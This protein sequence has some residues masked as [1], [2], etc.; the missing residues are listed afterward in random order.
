MKKTVL[1]YSRP[2]W[3]SWWWQVA[4][5]AFPEYTRVGVSEF[6]NDDDINF[7]EIFYQYYRGKNSLLDVSSIPVDAED[8]RLR[9]RL[10]QNLPKSQGSRMI[11]SAWQTISQILDRSNPHYVLSITV[12]SYVVD[13]LARACFMR[14]IKF[15]GISNCP[16]TGYALVTE[17]GEHNRVRDPSPDE[18][19]VAIASILSDDFKPKYILGNKPY[20]A[21]AHFQRALRY[22]AKEFIYWL[23]MRRD[24]LNY[25][26]MS[27]RYAADRKDLLGFSVAR[28]FTKDA[29]SRWQNSSLPKLYLP[30]HFVPEATVNYWTRNLDF[31]DYE[32]ALTEVVGILNGRYAIAAKEHPAAMGTRTNDFYE[33]LSKYNN[34]FFIHPD[35]SSLELISQSDIVLTWT[36]TVGLEAA[37][38]GKT[39][40][41]LGDPYYYSPDY[42]IKVNDLEDIRGMDLHF[43]R[44]QSSSNHG[45]RF[46]LHYIM[47]STVRGTF[48]QRGYLSRENAEKLG[49]S[50]G[51][52]R[53]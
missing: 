39:V 23:M 52:L 35:E 19:D 6:H 3:R 22:K 45:S 5:T 51:L 43:T 33:R 4:E 15:I 42:F 13:L 17:R 29:R 14:N 38:R 50:I 34:L 12:D 53:A 28:H 16:L 25:N 8:V 47:S 31:I 18:V 10:L 24:P 32:N 49:K 37:L 44:E 48:G 2:A 9:C 46:L 41:I 21:V 7:M 11:A 1:I 30:L 27:L 20:S 40:I 26:L 36:G